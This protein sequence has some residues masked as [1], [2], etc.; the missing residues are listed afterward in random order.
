VSETIKELAIRLTREDRTQKLVA[1]VDEL[2]EQ[3]EFELDELIVGLNFV[4]ATQEKAI[5][6]FVKSVEEMPEITKPKK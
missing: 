6:D 4:K 1:F 3:S 2:L 5:A